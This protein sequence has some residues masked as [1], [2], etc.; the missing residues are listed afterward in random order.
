MPAFSGKLKSILA[1]LTSLYHISRFDNHFF[2]FPHEFDTYNI[3]LLK[4]MISFRLISSE[5]M[6]IFLTCQVHSFE[7]VGV[8]SDFP[9]K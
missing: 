7:M 2:K 9:G 8:Y 3:N 6:G 4:C 1:V 5:S